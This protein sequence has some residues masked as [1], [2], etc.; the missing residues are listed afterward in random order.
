MKLGRL[1]PEGISSIDRGNSPRELAAFAAERRYRDDRWCGETKNNK[2][3][4]I[5][6][7]ISSP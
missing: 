6:D 3:Q 4:I 7:N 2:D 5:S 1:H